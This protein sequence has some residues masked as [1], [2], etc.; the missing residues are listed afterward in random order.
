MIDLQSVGLQCEL[1]AVEEILREALASSVPML[2]DA[3]GQLV[4]AGGKRL[5]PM[6]MMCAFR[7]LGGHDVDLVAPMA[8]AVELLHTA[9]LIHDDI[10][11]RSDTRRGR[12]TVNARWGDTLAL[13]AGDYVFVKILRLVARSDPRSIALLGEA[14]EVL[15]EGETLQHLALWDTGMGEQRY[16]EILGKKTAMLFAAC[17]RLGALA[18]EASQVQVQALGDY[19]FHLGVAFQIRDDTLDLIGTLEELGKP[20]ESDLVQGKVSLAL[21]HALS[22]STDALAALQSGNYVRL[23]HIL[24]ETGSIAYAMQRAEEHAESAVA[25]LW[26]VPKGEYADLL[27]EAALF[28]AHRAR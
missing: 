17:G 19:G 23:R 21:I 14:C 27:R 12:P 3:G 1:A 6:L 13:L 20:T 2:R 10:N 9:S 7:A 18:A 28:A 24:E 5:R 15:V 25:A 11:D 22:L 16:L 8:A 4:D 26:A